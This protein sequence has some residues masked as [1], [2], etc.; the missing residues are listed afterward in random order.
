MR[1]T[2]VGILYRRNTR[3]EQI[4][5]LLR[6]HLEVEASG[7]NRDDEQEAHLKSSGLKRSTKPMARS[8]MK[9]TTKPMRQRSQKTEELYRKERRPLVDR[10]LG[11]DAVD[12]TGEPVL[13]ERCG[14]PA[15][16]IHEPLTRGRGGSI[17]DEDNACKLCNECHRFV[18]AHPAQST[19]E[20]W[21]I[22]SGGR[23]P[24]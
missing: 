19:A 1:R 5:S 13:C 4:P 18:H 22:R 23:D 24:K 8:P 16:V 17:T 12:G 11:D 3:T 6:R 15:Q 2:A 10:L 20:G 7:Y 21:L 14:K 9:P